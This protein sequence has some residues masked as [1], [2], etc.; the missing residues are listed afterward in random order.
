[1]LQKVNENLS[2]RIIVFHL[3][4][5]HSILILHILS[6]IWKIHRKVRKFREFI[7]TDVGPIHTETA[8]FF[9]KK[10]S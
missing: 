6:Q 8:F 10:Y 5:N 1:M 2:L 7:A 4:G 9:V 3:L